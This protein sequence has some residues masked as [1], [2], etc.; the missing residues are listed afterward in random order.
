[1]VT[2]TRE[3]AANTKDN[4]SMVVAVFRDRT[5]A[6][7]AHNWLIARG[8][9]ASEINIMMSDETRGYY[10]K[11]NSKISVGNLA[12]EGVAAGGTLGAAVGGT[13]AAIMA[14]GTA[15]AIP[16]LGWVVA[17]PIL[18]GLAGVGAGAVTG[19]LVGGLIGLG[20]PESNAHAYEEALKKGGVVIGVVPDQGDT[21][22]IKTH[23]E[24][25]EGENVICCA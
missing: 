6:T 22:D 24:K 10:E 1:M 8:Y 21:D 25:L 17:G 14:I 23:F 15:V 2:S 9:S 5:N 7:Q 4:K 12:T 13:V 11:E 3:K 19:G 20:I 16:G 18:A